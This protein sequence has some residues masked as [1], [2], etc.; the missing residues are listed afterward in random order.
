MVFINAVRGLGPLADSVPVFRE[1]PLHFSLG[2]Y[3]RFIASLD[4]LSTA[5]RNVSWH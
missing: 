3:D 1:V 2:F 4:D 5:S